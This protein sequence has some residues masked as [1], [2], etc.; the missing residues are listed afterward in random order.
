M[1]CFGSVS[2]RNAYI[3]ASE[4]KLLLFLLNGKKCLEYFLIIYIQAN[5]NCFFFSSWPILCWRVLMLELHISRLRPQLR[6]ILRNHFWHRPD[7]IRIHIREP[8]KKIA[9]FY[10]QWGSTSVAISPTVV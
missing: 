10:L 1:K 2:E 7:L 5:E 3:S 6:G 4:T 8:D 9:F